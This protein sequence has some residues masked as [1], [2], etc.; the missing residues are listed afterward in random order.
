[1]KLDRDRMTLYAITE[2]KWLNDDRKYEKIE[3][4]LKG[5]ITM[6]QMREKELS[7]DVFIT[8]AKKVKKLCDKY[9]VPLII[10]DNV[11]VALKSGAD[12]VHLGQKDMK[13]SEARA[14][15]GDSAIIGASARTVET[16]IDAQNQGADYLGSGA[17][18]ETATKNDAI[19]IP[20]SRIKEICDTVDIPVVAIGGIKVDNV[21]ELSGTGIDGIAT[22]SMVFGADN[23]EDRCKE[24]KN[25]LKDVVR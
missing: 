21:R 8:E 17:A 1:M 22:V 16:A 14:I 3:S 19:V 5:G 25:I 11:N 12:G 23:I 20:H 2:G 4:A 9:G 15:L 7:E 18:F 13:V 10:N 6:L 24:L